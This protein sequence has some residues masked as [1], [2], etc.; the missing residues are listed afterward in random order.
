MDESRGRGIAL[1]GE[2][3]PVTLISRRAYFALPPGS[4]NFDFVALR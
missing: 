4:H 2:S 3:T 1:I